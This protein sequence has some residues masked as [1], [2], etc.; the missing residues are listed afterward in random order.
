MQAN[1]NRDTAPEVAIRR[2]LHAAGLRYRICAR[3]IAGSR[4]TVDV[5]FGPSRVAV[6]IRGCFWHGCPEHHRPARQNADFW[7]EKITKNIERDERK[8]LDLEAAGWLL[9]VI[10]EHEDPVEAADRVAKLV[11]G[12]RVRPMCA[13]TAD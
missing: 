1:R 4:Q 3:P 12:R 9:V 7:R 8:R 5:A 11:A 13:G 2:R 6:E 10:W